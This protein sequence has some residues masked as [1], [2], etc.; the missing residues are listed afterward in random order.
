MTDFLKPCPAIFAVSFAIR[1]F[2]VAL[3]RVAVV[4][5]E[6]LDSIPTFYRPSRPEALFFLPTSLLLLQRRRQRSPRL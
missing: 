1:A 4:I 5:S 2:A 6:A 3:A